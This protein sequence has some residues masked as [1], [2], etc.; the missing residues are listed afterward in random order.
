[1]KQDVGKMI[2]RGWWR[3]KVERTGT[4]KVRFFLVHLTLTSLSKIGP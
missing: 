4:R 1:M 2:K 3:R